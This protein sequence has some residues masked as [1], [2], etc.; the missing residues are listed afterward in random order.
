MEYVDKVFAPRRRIVREN[1][2]LKIYLP[3]RYNS[4]WQRF[5]DRKVDLLI[6]F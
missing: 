1:E 4:L 5:E 3:K 2:R 6:V